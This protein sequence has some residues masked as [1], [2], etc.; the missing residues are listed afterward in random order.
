MKYYDIT[1]QTITRGIK[2]QWLVFVLCIVVFVAV[3][4]IAS[5][6][7]ADNLSAEGSGNAVPLQMESIDTMEVEENYYRQIYSNLQVFSENLHEY[8]HRVSLDSTIND[9]QKE[10]LLAMMEAIEQYQKETLE[11]INEQLSD[12]KTLYIPMEIYED[13]MQ[14]YED[15]Y[16]ETK[17]TLLISQSAVDL[18]KSMGAVTSTDTTINET[19]ADLLKEAARYGSLQVSLQ[20]YEVILDQMKNQKPQLRQQSEDMKRQLERAQ[21]KLE[22]MCEEVNGLLQDVAESNHLNLAAMPTEEELVVT[23]SHTNRLA[24]AEEA[25]AA[26]ITFCGLLGVVAG[27]YC[28]VWREARK[29]SV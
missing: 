16:S 10:K 2:R 1:L 15:L 18:L 21:D 29:R 17:D 28:S 26:M 22:P 9:E 4:A 6:L 20:R 14:N 5:F 23:I 12:G 25:T 24:T 19:Y 8:L 11:P 27:A 13:I 7:W 3:G